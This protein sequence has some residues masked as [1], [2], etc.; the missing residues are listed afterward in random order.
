VNDIASSEG[1]DLECRLGNPTALGIHNK[2]VLVWA[3]GKGYIHIG[4]INGGE[5]SHKN[6]RELAIQVQSND[7]YQ[8]LASVFEYDWDASP[9][10]ITYT[11]YLPIVLKNYV[12]PAKYLLITEVFYDP[13]SI[14]DEMGEWIEIYNPAGFAVDLSGYKVGDEEMKDGTEGMYQFPDGESIP[15]GGVI[16]VAQTATGFKELNGFN[17]DFEFTDTDPSVPD[18][19]PYLAWGT[20]DV[21]LANSGD[22]VLLLDDDDNPVD[23]VVYGTGHYSGVVAHPGVSPGRSLERYPPDRD[24]NDCEADF[25]ERVTP[26]PGVVS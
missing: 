8:Y 24:T 18:L 6:N 21:F 10:L 5:T 11:V 16:V 17:P 26:N 20:G 3:N 7:A 9:S 15:A 23:V 19:T 22:E 14:E 4:S 25:R 13:T 1:L 2:M 12:P